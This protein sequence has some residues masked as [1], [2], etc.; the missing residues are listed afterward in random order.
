[1]ADSLIAV[2]DGEYRFDADEVTR[3]LAAM[4][5]ETTFTPAAGRVA[6]LSAG[7][8]DVSHEG[9]TVALIEVDIDGLSLDIQWWDPDVLA[10]TVAAV[11]GI[12]GLPDDGSVVLSDWAPDVVAL[13]PAMTAADVH[14]LAA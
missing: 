10:R 2:P 1:M 14:A 13:R 8:I 4:W 9:S 5:P 12:K 11:T 7:R 6:T 3:V